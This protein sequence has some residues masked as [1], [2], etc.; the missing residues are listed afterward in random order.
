MSEE[1]EHNL[2]PDEY[3][4]Q[5]SQEE[6]E[7]LQKFADEA[8]E[9]LEQPL[10]E[11]LEWEEM[12]ESYFQ[13]LRE[14]FNK[15]KDEISQREFKTYMNKNIPIWMMVIRAGRQRNGNEMVQYFHTIT[16]DMDSGECN[17]SYELVTEKELEEN[18][19]IK[20]NN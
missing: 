10:G 14:R 4:N 20:Y 8:N 12:D 6:M 3:W 17:G 18:F 16:E 13:S 5:L 2:M 11:T 1:F 15:S 7:A 9:Y 19:N